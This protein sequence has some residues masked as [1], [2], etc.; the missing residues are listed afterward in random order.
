MW[1]CVNYIWHFLSSHSR[2]GTHS[3]FVYDLAD[4]AI[5]SA[6]IAQSING[7]E[8]IGPSY[9]NTLLRILNHLGVRSIANLRD[10]GAVYAEALILPAHAISQ[11]KIEQYLHE[12]KLIVIEGIYRD[13]L[14]K[15][16][17]KAVT[18]LPVVTVAI[19]LLHFGLLIQR[20]GQVKENF[21]LRYPFWVK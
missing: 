9:K 7:E 16:N 6:N 1:F 18:T 4:K 12:G 17:W 19:D 13:K 8:K 2:H 5:Y 14:S 15:K 10:S 3:P 21:K 20:E 11:D